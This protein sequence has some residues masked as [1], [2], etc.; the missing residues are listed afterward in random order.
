MGDIRIFLDL[1]SG[2]LYLAAL[3]Q[4]LQHRQAVAVA[5]GDSGHPAD[6]RLDWNDR[7]AEGAVAKLA[8]P[9]VTSSPRG[10]IGSQPKAEGGTSR[11]RDDALDLRLHRGLHAT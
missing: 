3:N 2:M 7:I 11:D 9:V 8:I 10:P 1:I 6:L 5:G 4:P